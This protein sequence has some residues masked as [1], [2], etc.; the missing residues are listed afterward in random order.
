MKEFPSLRLLFIRSSYIDDAVLEAMSDLPVL[1]SLS[2]SDASVGDSG[3]VHVA[4][5][6]KLRTLRLSQTAV[7]PEGLHVLKNASA[8]QKLELM[9][10]QFNDKSLE[11]LKDVRSLRELSMHGGAVTDEGLKHLPDFPVLESFVVSCRGLP[12]QAIQFTDKGL[13]SIAKTKISRLHVSRAAITDAG[14]KHLE[15]MTTLRS[16]TLRDTEVTTEGLESLH[17]ALPA[18]RVR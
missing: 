12:G 5:L 8:L 11:S 7:T 4:K 18:L 6:P 15:T 14:L 9:G 3:L 1:S 16:L 10:R 2:F 13:E 17:K